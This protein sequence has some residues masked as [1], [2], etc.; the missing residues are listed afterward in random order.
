MIDTQAFKSN[1]DL[2]NIVE[3]DLGT[4]A[5]HS[6]RA[7]LYILNRVQNLEILSQTRSQIISIFV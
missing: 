3:Q 2:R 7:S 6:G 4:P 1:Y 5:I